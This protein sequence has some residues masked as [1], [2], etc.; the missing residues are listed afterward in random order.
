M[1]AECADYECEAQ[2]AASRPAR[3]VCHLQKTIEV[4][5]AHE[6]ALCTTL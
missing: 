5:Q 3:P 1:C 4:V 2:S 6:V